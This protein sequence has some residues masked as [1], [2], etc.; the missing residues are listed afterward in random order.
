M[1]AAELGPIRPQS[2]TAL[3][4]ADPVAHARALV[5]LLEAAGPA[6]EAAK[7]LTPPIRD[8]LF[9]HNLLRLLLPR[10]IGG[11]DIPLP[12]FAEVCEAIAIGDASAAWGVCQGNVS[13]MTSCAYL[14]PEV[15]RE[16]FGQ[17]RAALAWGA[18]HNRARAVIVEGG[19]RVTGIWDFASGNRHC[20]M[21]GAHLPA[22]HPDGTP[23]LSPEGKPEDVTV[24]FRRDQA[25]VTPE[26]N[27][28][29]LRGTG[30]DI[31]EVQ[32]LFVPDAHAC[33]RDRFERRRD[34]RPITAITSHLCYATG[35]SATALGVARG[36]LSRYVALARGKTARAGAQP[37][38]ENHSVQSEVAQ[39]EAT[40]RANR[41]YLLGT[42]REVWAEAAARG[43]VS[44]ENRVALRLATTSVMR[45]ATDVSIACYRAAGTTAVLESNEF[46]RRFRDAMS[47]SQHLQ[48]TPWHLETVG[49]WLLG[50]GE[51]PAFV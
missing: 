30:S 11:Q 6:I 35:F 41:M 50:S 19:Y 46:E 42:A 9:G 49:R 47:V 29:G 8:A 2:P 39:L 22:V 15:A 24:L 34:H 17:P 43:E 5:P 25:R 1:A 38:A 45:Q 21:L 7:E 33:V 28:L 27:S 37:M 40:L 51:K 16:F 14:A 12:D 13:A 31:Y 4:A 48:A 3:S 44:M 10:E 18:R 23:R 32:D 20:T 26:W 36:L